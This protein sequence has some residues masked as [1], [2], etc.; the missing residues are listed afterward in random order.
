MADN[1]RIF[2]VDKVV[3]HHAVSDEMHNWDD[4]AVSKW[5]SSI[6]RNRGYAGVAR[7]NHFDPDEGWE[8]YSQAHWCLHK[9]DKDGNK[10]GWRLTLLIADP[11]NNVAWHA[12]NW[13]VN[14]SSY[15]IEVAGNYLDKTLPD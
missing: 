2:P 1:Q 8:T 4:I 3:L 11:D 7:S 12:G 15:G 14:Q 6:G 9:Y 13:A 5:F 10:Y